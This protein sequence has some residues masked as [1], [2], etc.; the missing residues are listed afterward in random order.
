MGREDGWLI[1]WIDET[2]AL[3][4]CFCHFHKHCIDDW[5]QRKPFCPVHTDD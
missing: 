1:P 5:F 3:L 4:N 2:V